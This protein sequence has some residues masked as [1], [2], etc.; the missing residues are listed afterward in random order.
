MLS[1][2]KKT[3]GDRISK[4]LTLTVVKD[5]DKKIV[6][7]VDRNSEILLSLDLSRRYSFGDA[8]R[9]IVYD[10]IGVTVEEMEAAIKDSKQIHSNNKVQSNPFYASCTLTASHF[11]SKKNERMAT[12]VLTYMSLMMWTS[13]HKGFF[14]YDANKQ[15][16]DYT[17][18]HLDN[19]FLI[20]SFPSV[21]A[22][23]QDNTVT[24]MNTYKARIIR[25]EDTDITWVVDSFWTRLKG[26]MKKIASEF[27]ENHEKGNYL[28]S[29]SDSYDGED[30]HEIDNVSFGIDRLTNKVYTKLTNRQYDKRFIK[31]SI[32]SAD[33]S[34]QKLDHLIEDIIDGD[35]DGRMR[36]LISAMIEFYL[37]QSGRPISYVAKGDFIAYMK[38]AFS[39]NTEVAQMALIKGTIDQWL[40][41]N[42]YKYGKA[43]YGKTLRI[44]YR[45]CI[46]MFFVFVI[47]YEAK[48][49]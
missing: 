23:I 15:V 16:M 11:L 48:L 12:S 5:L 45:R 2:L 41:E 13:L 19:T 33:T 29:D 14:K 44:Q 37:Q 28:N 35:D 30:Y 7:Y 36:R 4:S 8:D 43:K 3:F 25:C 9:Q 18:A 26:K 20:R 39:S 24:A 6:E 22:F 46:Y 38:T 27:Y 49:S 47:N 1:L 32:S 31:Y 21:F 10:A 42:M 40:D 17:I 34:Y